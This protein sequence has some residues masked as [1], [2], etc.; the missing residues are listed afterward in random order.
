MNGFYNS[1]SINNHNND[2]FPN[3][4]GNNLL[5]VKYLF[6][7]KKEKKSTLDE[8]IGLESVKEE[9]EY[10]IEFIKNKER[11]DQ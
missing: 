1:Y 9:I 3:I 10:Y 6:T 5:S 2:F 11:Y 8:V 7:K 4:Y